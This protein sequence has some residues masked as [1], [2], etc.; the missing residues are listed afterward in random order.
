MGGLTVHPNKPAPWYEFKMLRRNTSG[1]A[2]GGSASLFLHYKVID[3][4]LRKLDLRI[5]LKLAADGLLNTLC[6]NLCTHTSSAL[7]TCA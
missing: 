4:G 6:E 5:S 2:R 3:R 1:R 7:L